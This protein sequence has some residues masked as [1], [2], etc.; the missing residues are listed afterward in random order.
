MHLRPLRCGTAPP[1]RQETLAVSPAH[2]LRVAPAGLAPIGYRERDPKV[3][4]KSRCPHN[5]ERASP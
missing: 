2:R 4:A 1:C 3:R 5:N